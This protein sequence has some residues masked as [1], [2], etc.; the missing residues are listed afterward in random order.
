VA[1]VGGSCRK[2]HATHPSHAGAVQSMLPVK[3]LP[4]VERGR[5]FCEQFET[6]TILFSDIM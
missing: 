3:T 2:P 4:F 6:V 1:L 5:N